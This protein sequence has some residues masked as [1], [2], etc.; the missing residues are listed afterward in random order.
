MRYG[1]KD[2]QKTRQ[3]II[4]TAARRY[5]AEGLSAV[6]I[7]NLMADLGMTHGGFY[8][9]FADKEA[10]VAEAC[11]QGFSEQITR[12]STQLAQHP[13]QDPLETLVRDYLSLQH[14]SHPDTGCV[15]AALSGEMAH[16]DHRSRKAFTNG[17]QQMLDY[18]APA[19]T[20]KKC[21]IKPEAVL[22]LMVGS[23][24]LARAVSDPLLSERLL[25]TAGNTILATA[26]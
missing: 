3:R 22:G 4:R 7:A 24:M 13:G 18:L 6:G 21:K 1:P 25:E 26:E 2:K 12:W 10:L 11:T 8:A 20:Q 16:R 9:H 19:L 14:R 17:I 15:A 23:M 5:R